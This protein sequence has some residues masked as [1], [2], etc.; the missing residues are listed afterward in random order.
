[1][2]FAENKISENKIYKIESIF[3]LLCTRNAGRCPETSSLLKNFVI[4]MPR[5]SSGMATVSKTVPFGIAGSNPALG[6]NP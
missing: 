5:S 1:M 4:K 3:T 2:E 6:V